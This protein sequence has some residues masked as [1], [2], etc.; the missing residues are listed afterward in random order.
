[1]RGRASRQIIGNSK[2]LL[3]PLIR[4]HRSEDAW[5]EASWEIALDLVAERIEEAGREATAIWGG[6][7]NLANNYGVFTGA[8][9]LARFANLYGYQNWSPAMVCWGLGGFGVGL[10]GALETNT[11]EDMGAN[12]ELIVM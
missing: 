10:T 12:A 9:M 4:E 1:M 8:Q 3:K 11:K 5:R 6:H 7:G 2:R